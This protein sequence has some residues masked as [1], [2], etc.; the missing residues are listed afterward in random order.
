MARKRVWRSIK[1]VA[2]QLWLLSTVKEGEM[3]SSSGAFTSHFV[4]FVALIVLTLSCKPLSGY[5]STEGAVEG[6]KVR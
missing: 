2:P 4:P 3:S 5:T 6:G 1:A